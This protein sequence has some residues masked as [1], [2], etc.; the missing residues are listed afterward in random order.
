MSSLISVRRK[1]EVQ[2]DTSRIRQVQETARQSA[3]TAAER[4]GPMAVRSREYAAERVLQARGWSA[5]R[6]ERAAGYIEQDLA[7]RVS[8][9]LNDTAHRIE[10]PKAAG[11]SRN[12][13]LIALAAIA[14]L[15]VAGAAMTRRNA[16]QATHEQYPETSSAEE[17]TPAH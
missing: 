2:I 8:A 1:P 16:F 14:A 5:P 12:A 6:L 17:G 3:I 4:V 15:G 10:P 13:G 9:W 7:P 11:R